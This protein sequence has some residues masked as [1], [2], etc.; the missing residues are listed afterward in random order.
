MATVIQFKRSSTQ[1]DVPATS[2]LALGEVAI[3][4]GHHDDNTEEA[5][6]VASIERYEAS[7][8]IT[9]KAYEGD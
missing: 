8:S 6:F 5:A 9:G 2:D 7:G 3:E 1:N 4:G